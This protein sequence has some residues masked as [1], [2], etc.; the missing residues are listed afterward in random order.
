MKLTK[1]AAVGISSS[2]SGTSASTDIRSSSVSCS[3]CYLLEVMLFDF[4][5][6]VVSSGTAMYFSANFNFV[7][8]DNNI[9]ADIP[10][11]SQQYSGVILFHLF[12]FVIITAFLVTCATPSQA[13]DLCY[14]P[15]RLSATLACC[16]GKSIKRNVMAYQ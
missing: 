5:K 1:A 3:Y 6:L 4:C 12:M 16:G 2:G 13:G 8:A 15:T 10:V 11:S 14:P 9:T 7:I